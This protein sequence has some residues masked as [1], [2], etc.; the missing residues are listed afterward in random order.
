[1]KTSIAEATELNVEVMNHLREGMMVS[2][3]NKAPSESKN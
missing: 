2:M 1:M 3:K